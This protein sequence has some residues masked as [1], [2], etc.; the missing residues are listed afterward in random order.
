MNRNTLL[1]AFLAGVLTLATCARAHPT[2]NAMTTDNQFFATAS[3]AALEVAIRADDVNAMTRAFANGAI[4]NA[5]GKFN[6][7]PLMVAVD[8]Q[9]PRAVAALLKAGA[10]PNAKALDGNGPVSLAVKS[11]RTEPNGFGIMLAIFNGG[12]DPDT[13]QPDDDPVLMRFIL[14]HDAKGL[15]LMKSLGANLNIRDRA[16]RPLINNVAFSGDWDMAW[17]LIELGVEIDNDKSTQEIVKVMRLKVPA[18]GSTQYSY[19]LKVWQFLKDKGIAVQP[20]KN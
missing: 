13:R 9:S 10:L 18:P 1:Q 20:L 6:I 4:V 11:C 5:T 14:D 3:Q 19:K 17:A 12:G 7:T 8:A 2:T 15:A 16:G